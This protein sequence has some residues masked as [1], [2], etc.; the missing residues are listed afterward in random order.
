MTRENQTIRFNFKTL[1]T[2]AAILVVMIVTLR[3]QGRIWWCKL[4]DYAPYINDAWSPHTS[5][6]LFDPYSLTH[7]LHGVLF[8][9]IA[10][11]IFSKLHQN[12]RFCVAILA[13]AAWE[14]LENS[15]AVIAHYRA[16]TASLDYY[17]DSIFNSVGDVLACGFGFWLASKFGWK[18]SIVFFLLTEIV[19]VF[20]IRDSLLINIVMLTCPIE[21][22]KT[23][24]IS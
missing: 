8:C 22:I 21:W 2:T 13:E 16:N 23:W 15:N 3:V 6:H 4:G 20:W 10:W 18:L 17:G 14:I 7:V 24:Q 1:L 5:Q 19:L 11:L 9:G 12:W